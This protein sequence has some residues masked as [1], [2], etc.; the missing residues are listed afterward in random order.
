MGFP[1]TG[2]AKSHSGTYN[3]VIYANKL[4]L[5]FYM[6]T[7]F[8][9]IANTD[10]EGEI[11]AHGD[12]V[13]IRLIPDMVIR[14]YE[15]GTNLVY[16]D[17]D[18]G[19]VTL[20]IDKGKYFAIKAYDIDKAQSD[21]NYLDEW[22]KD[23]AEQMKIAIDADILSVL[24]SKANAD[25]LGATAGKQ[26]SNL[27]LGAVGAPLAITKANV[28]D[29]IVYADQILSEQSRPESDRW[30]VVPSWMKTNVLLSE[31]KDASLSG[32]EKSTLRNGRMGKIGNF[33]LYESQS[34]KHAVDSTHNCASIPF[35]HKSAVTFAS[36]LVENEDLKNP[37]DFG[38]LIRGLQVYGWEAVN[39]K[40]LG[41]IYGYGA[42]G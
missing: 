42:I 4:L 24:P 1:V 9:A 28:V 41:C 29:L 21:L 14:N 19:V 26:S 7:V 33:T 10:Y 38:D 40:G 39:P 25:N 5:K 32:D 17:P 12:K 27:N 30:M 15:K 6:M 22:T 18:A 35:G 8:G 16:D 23:G 37:N 11:K 2:T 20:A 13:E 34:V 3:P 36:Q 31:L